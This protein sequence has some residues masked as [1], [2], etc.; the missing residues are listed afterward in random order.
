MQ[1]NL[2]FSFPPQK[3][4][5]STTTFFKYYIFNLIY[6]SIIKSIKLVQENAMIYTAKI[7]PEIFADSDTTHHLLSV[8]CT[9]M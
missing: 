5:F 9:S 8:L 3:N 7:M 2:L 6:L 1:Q 4:Y